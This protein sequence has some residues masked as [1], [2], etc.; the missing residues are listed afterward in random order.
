MLIGTLCQPYKTFANQTI[1]NVIEQSLVQCYLDY[2]AKKKE[3]ERERKLGRDVSKSVKYDLTF[4]LFCRRGLL[5]V[6]GQNSGK[7]S[8]DKLQL[9]KKKKYLRKTPVPSESYL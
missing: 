4:V 3:C 5:C 7:L 9:L 8:F 6:R 2:D 1:R